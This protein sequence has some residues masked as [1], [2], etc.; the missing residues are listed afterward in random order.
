MSLEGSAD[1]EAFLLYIERL[2]CPTLERGQIVV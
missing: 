1:G 2:L